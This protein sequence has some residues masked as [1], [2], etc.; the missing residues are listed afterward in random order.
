MNFKYLMVAF[1]ECYNGAN[2]CVQQQ[3]RFEDESIRNTF[4]VCVYQRKLK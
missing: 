2:I 3:Y 4:N 1:K